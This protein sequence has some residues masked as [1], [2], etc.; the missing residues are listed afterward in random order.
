MASQNTRV[1]RKLAERKAQRKR[2]LYH[3]CGGEECLD[4][5][6]VAARKAKEEGK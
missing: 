5:A 2:T 6:C 1:R 3:T 4:R